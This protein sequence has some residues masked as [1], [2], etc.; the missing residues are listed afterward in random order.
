MIEGCSRPSEFQ[1]VCSSGIADGQPPRGP[2]APGEFA[3]VKSLAALA[4]IAN[5]SESTISRALSGH[6]SVN[7]QTRERIRELAA[8]YGYKPNQLARNLRLRRTN[9]IGLVLPLGHETGQQLSDN[10][11]LTLMGHLADGLTERGYDLLLSRVVP[12]DDQWLDS[13][14]DSG[15]VDGVILIGQ[16]DQRHVIDRTARRYAPLVVWGAQLPDQAHLTIGTDNRK[17]GALAAEHLLGLGRRMPMFLGNPVLPEFAQRLKGFRQ[18]CAAVGVAVRTLSLHLMPNEAHDAIAHAL[19]TG[20]MPDAI[21]AVSDIVAMSALRAL[22]EKGLRVPEDVAVIGYDDI[23]LAAY[24]S[25]S[26]STI[27]QDTRLGARLLIDALF[28]RIAGQAV[29]SHI[30]QPQLIVRRS[31]MA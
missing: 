20:P 8:A 18:T 13:L 4:R 26:L 28:R 1:C 22:S 30:L 17:G 24:T 15:R 10:F 9:A 6:S 27:R 2:N 16:S 21:F 5:V 3:L 11:F 7:A 25:P 31:T 29:E 23:T 19:D 14:V 12:R